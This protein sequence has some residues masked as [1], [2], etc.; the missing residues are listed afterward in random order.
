MGRI[1]VISVLTGALVSTLTN[2][3]QGGD[4][5]T[6]AEGGLVGLAI[7][8]TILG[9]EVAFGERLERLSVSLRLSVRMLLFGVGGFLGYLVGLFPTV[10][11][12]R[13]S[14]A[15]GGSRPLHAI[16]PPSGLNRHGPG[17][18]ARGRGHVHA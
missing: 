9:L 12:R 3:S 7:G 5:R 17:G 8:L 10:V 11:P 18:P 14:H 16:T 13:E 2:L 4:W 1:L 6:W 15:G